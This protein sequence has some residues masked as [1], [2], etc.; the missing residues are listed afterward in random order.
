MADRSH[1]YWCQTSATGPISLNSPLSTVG[2][3]PA[4]GWFLT[5]ARMDDLASVRIC[6]GDNGE[7]PRCLGLL[8]RFANG[9]Q[10]AVGRI[11]PDKHI[12]NDIPISSCEFREIS[13][14]G[15]NPRIIYRPKKTRST[16]KV[17]QNES[18]LPGGGC[19]EAEGEPVFGGWKEWTELPKH[20][21]LLWWFSLDGDVLQT[22]TAA[23]MIAAM[24][25]LPP[26]Q[27][28]G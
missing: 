24:P 17:P 16:A 14:E 13:D 11:R 12:S 25:S 1:V 4:R 21:Y 27:T 2:G 28:S 20:D 3:A 10:E 15:C 6:H 22:M 18:E 26:Y 7:S 8:L 19:R 9:S 5:L 23:D